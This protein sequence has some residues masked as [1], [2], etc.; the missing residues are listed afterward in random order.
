MLNVFEF[1][2]ESRTK[3]GT[4]AARKI[5][6]NG[7]VP[8]VLYGGSAQPENLVLSHNEV[9]KHLSHEAVYSHVLDI[10][11]DGKSEKAILKGV[12]RNPAK[13]QI[14]HLDFLRVDMAEQVK[15]HVPLHFVNE[16]RSV[17]C[18]KGGVATHA[19]VDVEVLCL[20]SNLPEFIEVD[21]LDLDIGESIHLSQLR[22]PTGVEVVALSH[23]PEHD[24][25][26]VSILSPVGSLQDEGLSGAA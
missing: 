3:T 8:A 24:A 16:Q 17:G 22:L 19:M 14:L 2:A 1:V 20:P 12:Q 11:V 7:Q 6:R 9:V 4:V 26:V 25:A 21:L 13:F 15:V 23:G 5:R 18:K 10:V